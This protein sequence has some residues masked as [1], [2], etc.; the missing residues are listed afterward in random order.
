MLQSKNPASRHIGIMPA[1]VSTSSLLINFPH[2]ASRSVAPTLFFFSSFSTMETIATLSLV[3]NVMQ[4]I[5]FAGEMIK[6]CRSIYEDGQTPF[7][8]HC[9]IIRLDLG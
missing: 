3:C 5:S 2:P 1:M 9:L 8:S 4:V 6:I 7:D